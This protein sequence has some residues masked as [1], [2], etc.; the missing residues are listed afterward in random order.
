M[1]EHLKYTY[2]IKQLRA[3]LPSAEAPKGSNDDNQHPNR[4]E[5]CVCLV[6]AGLHASEAL[7]H[8]HVHA[9][10]CDDDY[11]EDLW[12][13]SNFP[14]KRKKETEYTSLFIKVPLP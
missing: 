12:K 13:G 9:C 8:A 6:P 2:N 10:C 7:D 4:N 1:Q 14:F 5:N 3:L 11:T